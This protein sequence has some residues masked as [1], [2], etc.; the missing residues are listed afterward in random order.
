MDHYPRFPISPIF[1]PRS[2]S[3]RTQRG[4]ESYSLQDVPVELL[5]PIAEELSDHLPAQPLPLQQEVSPPDRRVGDEAPLGQVL[6]A[7][8]WLPDESQRLEA[9][10]YSHP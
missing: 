6:D 10:H 8:F 4:G 2:S 7:L 3:H 1:F 9:E 5:L